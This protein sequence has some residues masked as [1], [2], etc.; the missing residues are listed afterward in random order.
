MRQNVQP[1]ACRFGVALQESPCPMRFMAVH[2]LYGIARS[3]QE[4]SLIMA[5]FKLFAA[6]AVI[7]GLVAG[8]PGCTTSSDP[9]ATPKPASKATGT[10]AEQTPKA[11]S[12]SG[13]P[14]SGQPAAA[15][16]TQAVV[17][18]TS[19]A[20]NGPPKSANPGFWDE[21]PDVPKPEIMTEIDAIKIP[22]YSAKTET[23]QLTGKLPAD[24][25]N[26]QAAKNPSDPT[27]GDTLTIRFSAEPKTL[28]MI[29][30]TSAAQKFIAQY[31]QE[32]LANQ[33]KETFEYEPHIAS[34][35][36]VED[37]VKLSPETPGRERRV[38]LE[39]GPASSTLEVEYTAPPP[40][41]PGKNPEEPPAIIV[42]TSDAE[43]RP[44]PDCWIG[45]YP[46]GRILGASTTGYHLWSN[47][48]GK[49]EIS[50]LPSGKYTIK[51][52][53]EIYGKTE[54]LDDGSLV[55]TP[56]TPENPLNESLK[57]SSETS[58]T[59]KPGEW[60]DRHE[61]TYF[62]YYMRDDVK[63]SDGT[64]LTTRDI[65][66]GDSLLHNKFVDA[67][68]IRPYIQDLIECRAL[69]PHVVRMRYR[70]Q[71]FMAFDVTY[72]ITAYSPPFHFF[73]KIFQD[74]GLELTFDHLTPEEEES[75]KKVSIHGQKFGNFFNTDD[76]DYRAPLGT[77]PYVIGKWITSDRV[78]L[79][80]NT[81]YW[82][83]QLAGHVDRIII[84]FI[85]DQVSAMAALKAGEIDFFYD[86]T[87]EQ[88]FN[89]WQTIDPARRNDY[90]QASWYSPSFSYIGWNFLSPQFQDRRVRVAMALLFDRQQ[91]VDTKLHGAGVV[92][93]G[94]Q[95]YFGIGYDHEVAPIGYDPD[96]ARELLASAGWIDT[97]N[98]GILD[99]DGTKFDVT[100]V[101]PTGRPIAMQQCEIV[102]KNLKSVGINL[103]IQAFEFA[104]Y[105]RKMRAKECDVMSGRWSTPV[106]SDPYQIWHSSGAVRHNS[107]SN[108]ISFNNPQADSLIELLRT[109]VDEKKRQRIHWSFHRLLD[110]EQPYT[111]LWLS[112]EFGV[113]HKRFRNVKWY[114]LRPGFDMSEWYVPKNEQLH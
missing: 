93:S 38:A 94:T 57:S 36:V 72:G 31:V 48:Q 89:D 7:G 1:A 65:E 51:V 78:E 111:F 19:K 13:M 25:G 106:E 83:P 47:A 42:A 30:E 45:V 75:Q 60:I 104:T 50:G 24:V 76:R 43:G 96:K 81:N 63:W 105:V 95:Y 74:E 73:S 49:V 85:P 87:P 97:D 37:S 102:Q 53:A 6:M 84:K 20:T 92:V 26:A 64:P 103:N 113:Y 18:D 5:R 16:E 77:G 12:D 40:A 101:L 58:L 68:S 86:M 59:L 67:D 32:G 88:Y 21:Y 71:Y 2:R 91:F 114:R 8:V 99:R 17:A 39:G 108:T 35:W 29:T 44:V 46:V 14:G 98:D 55:V 80:R 82:N 79:V 41:E 70:Q 33:N 9:V 28:N 15:T 69:G 22:R 54:R 109:T 56:A 11:N 4:G 112:K 107:G 61:Q 10:P 110:Q 34:K 3:N 90:V 62:T 66:F 23:L 27:T 100:V 52:G